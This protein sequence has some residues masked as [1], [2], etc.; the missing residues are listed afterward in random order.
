MNTS[1]GSDNSLGS[2]VSPFVKLRDLLDGLQPGA[3]PI[4]M[5]IGEPKH[6]MPSFLMERISEAAADFGKYPPNAG[7]DDLRRAIADW[8]ERRYRLDG[9]LDPMR[10][11]IAIAGSREGLFSGIFPA[12]ERRRM[13]TRPAVLIPNPFYQVYAGAAIS[14]GAEPVYLGATHN[15]GFLPDLDALESDPELLSRTIAF[16]L[17]S[18]A[19][20]QGTVADKAYL[21]RAIGLA[22]RHGF[23]LFADECYSEVYTREPPPGALE[24]AAEMGEGFANVI[25]YNSLSKRSNLP[26]LRM[27]LAAGDPEFIALLSQFRAVT[28][29]QVPLPVQHAAAAIWRDEAHVEASRA[30]Y[31]QKFDDAD[32]ILGGR[33]GYVRPGGG[34]FIWLDASRFGGGETATVTLWKRCGVK[35]LPGAYLTRG[36]GTDGNPGSAYIR[37]AL[38]QDAPTTRQGLERI[39][40]TLV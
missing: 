29:P 32:R 14:A 36:S 15:T 2:I 13:V 5:T 8:L 35:V 39:V 9:R 38:V 40:A 16:Y 37:V 3:A 26:G 19:N 25:V 21:A 20:P 34:F 4:D 18:P 22:R 28:A 1:T 27:G 23:M 12:R 6:A 33:F 11:V 24:V 10:H 31:R 7:S 30:L 17:C